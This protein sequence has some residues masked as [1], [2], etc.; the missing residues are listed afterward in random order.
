MRAW[1]NRMRRATWRLLFHRMLFGE[2]AADGRMLRFTRISPSTCI[3]QEDRLE[4]A[5]HVFIGHF[6]FIEASGGVRIAEGVQVTNF[7]SIVSHSSH[8][9]LRVM[10]RSYATGDRERV[11]FV[12]APIQI[13][14]YSF[15]GP[16]S[17]IEAGTSLGKGCVVTAYSAVRGE[18]PDFS[19]IRGNPAERVGDTRDADAKLLGLHPEF[20][21]QYLAWARHLPGRD[22]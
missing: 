7:V 4:L 5:D 2:R 17:L 15:I 11:G 20:E 1:L 9:A 10:G 18:F 8:A 6:N 3:E 22:R 12:A 19:I 16:H 13:G 14:A 21:A